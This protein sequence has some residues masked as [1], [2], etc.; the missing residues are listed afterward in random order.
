MPFVLQLMSIYVRSELKS[1]HTHTH[2]HTYTHIH[3]HT[4]VTAA[5]V[6]CCLAN[7]CL[8]T[9]I[10]YVLAGDNDQCCEWLSQSHIAGAWDSSA[11][12]EKFREAGVTG[13]DLID[14]EQTYL[15]A[16]GITFTPLINAIIRETRRFPPKPQY[17]VV[18]R[19]R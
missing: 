10:K 18:R 15:I 6:S 4:T 1:A 17:A 11:A 9:L 12:V 13:E 2:T 5:R 16:I 14:V 8:L 7:I 3:T 19:P